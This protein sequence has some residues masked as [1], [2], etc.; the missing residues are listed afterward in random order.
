[1]ATALLVYEQH[2]VRT[3]LSDYLESNSELTVVG[4]ARDGREAVVLA[5]RL[6]PDLV[7]MDSWLG[8][9]AAHCAARK[10]VESCSRSRVL[11]VSTRGPHNAVENWIRSGISGYLL[12]ESTPDELLRAIDAVLSGK[13]YL[14]PTIAQR[15]LDVVARPQASGGAAHSALTSRELEVLQ[16]VAEG[17]ST[18]EVAAELGIAFRTAEGYRSGVMSKLGIHKVPDLVRYAVREGLIAA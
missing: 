8:G 2:I 3:T 18:K 17:R 1:M 6:R 16:L 5:H 15:V 11:I 7:I 10:I 4:E 13:S 12:E 14:C 9:L